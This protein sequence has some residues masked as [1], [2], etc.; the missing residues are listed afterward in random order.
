MIKVR[1]RG[2]EGG[3]RTQLVRTMEPVLIWMILIHL[4]WGDEWKNWRVDDPELESDANARRMS[5]KEEKE[6]FECLRNLLMVDGWC[7]NGGQGMAAGAGCRG[8]G[9]GESSWKH[10]LGLAQGTGSVGLL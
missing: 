8:V 3:A 10:H 6:A 1:F 4:I 2:Y 7:K 5:D 9:C